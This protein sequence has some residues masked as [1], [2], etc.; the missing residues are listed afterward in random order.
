MNTDQLERR[1]ADNWH[2]KLWQMWIVLQTPDYQD[3]DAVLGES[4]INKLAQLVQKL[5]AEIKGKTV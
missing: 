5:N 1:I 3:G 4:D 2:P